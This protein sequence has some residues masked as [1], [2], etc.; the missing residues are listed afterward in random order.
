M[1]EKERVVVTVMGQDRV[2]IVA[3]VSEVLADNKVNIIDLT[4]TEMH[5]MFVMIVLAEIQNDGITVA[6]LQERL[7]RKAEEL[8]VQVLAQDESVFRY[9]HRI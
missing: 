5:G 1:D 3:G 7:K 4:S 8:G 2:G 9:L 6:E